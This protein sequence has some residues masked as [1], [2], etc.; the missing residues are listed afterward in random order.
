VTASVI[1]F[2]AENYQVAVSP[3]MSRELLIAL[4][5][6]LPNWSVREWFNRPRSSSRC[7]FAMFI[8]IQRA[9]RNDWLDS[10][11]VR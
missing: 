10:A 6:F 4:L 9:N 7:A 3:M 2:A 8:E 11:Y 5:S 1:I